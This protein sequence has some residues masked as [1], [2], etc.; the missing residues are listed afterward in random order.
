MSRFT[1]LLQETPPEVTP[2]PEV[3]SES[4]KVEEV[5]VEKPTKATKK[6]S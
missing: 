3:K 4:V 1:D 5:V 2:E 6:K